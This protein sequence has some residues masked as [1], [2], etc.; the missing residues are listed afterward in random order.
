MSFILCNRASTFCSCRVGKRESG[1]W[2]DDRRNIFRISHKHFKKRL[3]EIKI[4]RPVILFIDEHSSHLSLHTSKFCSEHSIVLVALYPN[5]THLIQPMDVAVFRT[6][7]GGWKDAF[8]QWR[9]DHCDSPILRKIHFCPLLKKVMDEKLTSSIFINGFR[10]CGLVPWDVNA[11]TLPNQK[12][13]VAKKEQELQEL[14]NGI[15]FMEK[16]IE[17][18]KITLFKTSENWT[19][20]IQDMALFTRICA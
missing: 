20:D 15:Y 17:K 4:P 6:L 7:K 16:Y 19:G 14:K 2:M 10:K 12:I 18:D 5:A 11:I 1:K 8:H 13:D 9:I 3:T